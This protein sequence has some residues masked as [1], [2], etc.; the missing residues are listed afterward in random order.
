M[1]TLYGSSYLD[2]A[3]DHGPGEH[4]DTNAQSIYGLTFDMRSIIRF[5]GC[6][7]HHDVKIGAP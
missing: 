2:G 3:F 7:N 4:R 6:V 1:D 5:N